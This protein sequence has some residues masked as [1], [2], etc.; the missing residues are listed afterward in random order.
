MLGTASIVLTLAFSYTTTK[1][2]EDVLKS[3]GEINKISV[4]RAEY[5]PKQAK[6][7]QR[8]DNRRVSADENLDF[9]DNLVK[10]LSSIVGVD[11]VCPMLQESYYQDCLFFCGDYANA[12]VQLCGLDLK[13]PTTVEKQGLKLLPG[14]KWDTGKQGNTLKVVVGSLGGFEFRNFLTAKK[15]EDVC[16][17]YWDAL[18][19]QGDA[20]PFVDLKK[21]KI[22]LTLL[23]PAGIKQC[24][25][26]LNKLYDKLGEGTAFDE[27]DDEIDASAGNFSYE[28]L[29][30]QK[31][32]LEVS[33]LVTEN[34][35]DPST[36]DWKLLSPIAD[37]WHLRGKLEYIYVDIETMKYL[38]AQIKKNQSQDQSEGK[39]KKFAY[40]NILVVAKDWDCVANVV[41]TIHSKLNYRTESKLGDIRERQKQSAGLRGMLGA[42]GVITLIVSA[43][44]IANMMFMSISER[45]KEIGVMKVL[46]CQLNNIRLMFLAEAGIVGLLGGILGTASSYGLG[47][48]ISFLVRFVQSGE[49]LEKYGDNPLLAAILTGVND[50]AKMF[51]LQEGM[52]IVVIPLYLFIGGVMFGT[53]I[54]LLSGLAPANRAMKISALAAIKTD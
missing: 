29:P 17:D 43:L 44:G 24:Q 32:K 14:G 21:D 1:N 41:D 31:F 2:I 22:Q 16:V 28:A 7:G 30:G 25:K 13:N 33:G 27:D 51:D 19:G 42:L 48:L 38:S 40:S 6:K 36:R 54:G 50:F 15:Y 37:D 12:Y 53:V 26:E 39:K 49:F 18:H 10:K 5:R 35:F 4:L 34:G 23:T 9:D 11:C 45:T 46:G 8:Q 52:D 20:K 47:K 3:G